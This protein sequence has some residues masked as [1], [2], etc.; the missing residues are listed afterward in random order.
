[1]ENRKEKGQTM[2]EYILIVAVVAIAAIGA[3]K[4]FGGSIS[5]GLSKIAA[6][7]SNTIGIGKK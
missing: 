2:T 6:E 4:L 7:I 5:G 3:L 1:M